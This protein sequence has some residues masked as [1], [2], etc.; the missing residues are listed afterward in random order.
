MCA[1]MNFGPAFPDKL[2]RSH[3]GT[4]KALHVSV[5]VLKQR[6]QEKLYNVLIHHPFLTVSV[7]IVPT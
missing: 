6:Y 7:P 1:R 4:F 3:A 5:H 2:D